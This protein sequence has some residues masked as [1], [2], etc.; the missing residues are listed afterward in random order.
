MPQKITDEKAERRGN[1]SE[2]FCYQPR[3]V[4]RIQINLIDL[5]YYQPRGVRWR[6]KF[7]HEF[8]N[9]SQ[10]CLWICNKRV[11]PLSL[12]NHNETTYKAS[13]TRGK[14]FPL[15]TKYIFVSFNF[16]LN[17]FCL[18]LAH[19]YGFHNFFL[20]SPQKLILCTARECTS[21]HIVSG[22]DRNRDSSEPRGL[23]T[24]AVIFLSV[25]ISWFLWVFV[26][27]AGNRRSF[28]LYVYFYDLMSR[29]QFPAFSSPAHKVNSA[30]WSQVARKRTDDS[31]LQFK[32]FSNE[33]SISP[34]PPYHCRIFSLPNVLHRT[35]RGAGGWG[36]LFIASF[37]LRTEVLLSHNYIYTVIC[38]ASILISK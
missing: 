34:F 2:L 38:N 20:L 35:F 22:P 27:F 26:A 17:G 21:F 13:N 9:V 24:T 10:D 36:K 32:V 23:P 15:A 14:S 12:T 6:R 37:W 11:S 33:Q 7:A 3:G 29:K 25:S 18:F 31:K 1:S 5:I 8:A 19:F 28:G 4:I 16:L 30:K